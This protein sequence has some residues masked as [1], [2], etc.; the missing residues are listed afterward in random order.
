MLYA[1]YFALKC[2][3]ARECSCFN[4]FIPR[5]EHENIIQII[6][7][8]NRPQD[9]DETIQRRKELERDLRKCDGAFKEL[10]LDCDFLENRLRT[11]QARVDI[12]DQ[13]HQVFRNFTA[14][15][16]QNLRRISNLERENKDLRR[17]YEAVR[18]KRETRP[19]RDDQVANL[20]EINEDLQQKIVELKDDLL[21]E[22][23]RAKN[24]TALANA[25]AEI[26]RL[27]KLLVGLDERRKYELMREDEKCK[28]DK[29]CLEIEKTAIQDALAACEKRCKEISDGNGI[30][31]LRKQVAN[32]TADIK[33]LRQKYKK[34]L[35]ERILFEN[36]SQTWRHMYEARVVEVN[37]ENKR[38][39]MAEEEAAEYQRQAQTF[40]KHADQFAA[41]Y[42]SYKNRFDEIVTRI[43]HAGGRVVDANDIQLKA[44]EEEMK[45]LKTQ[46]TN[47]E[48]ARQM[49]VDDTALDLKRWIEAARVALLAVGCYKEQIDMAGL[50][51]PSFE[52]LIVH[53]MEEFRDS[54]QK[55]ENLSDAQEWIDAARKTIIEIGYK[56]EQINPAGLKPGDFE[57]AMRTK[58]RDLL[59]QVGSQFS[60]TLLQEV[61]NARQTQETAMQDVLRHL[62]ESLMEAEQNVTKIRAE[63]MILRAWK[64][65]NS[66]QCE[67]G[68]D[69]R[70]ESDP[71]ADHNNDC[72]D[73]DQYPSAESQLS[74]LDPEVIR[75]VYNDF[76][77]LARKF[78]R[79]ISDTAHTLDPG[80]VLPKWFSELVEPQDRSDA[81]I[82]DINNLTKL[83]ESLGSYVQDANWPGA[84]A[85]WQ[86]P[87]NSIRARV[88]Q[89]LR[90][91]AEELS[92]AASQAH[93]VAQKSSPA[94]EELV[95]VRS[96]RSRCYQQRP[97]DLREETAP[98]RERPRALYGPQWPLE[99]SPSVYPF[100]ERTLSPDPQLTG[101]APSP[102][103]A[104]I[105]GR[106][107]FALNSEN[108]EQNHP[109]P[110]PPNADTREENYRPN[111]YKGRD[112]KFAPRAQAEA[113]NTGSSSAPKGQGVNQPE[114]RSGLRKRDFEI[115][116]QGVAPNS[117]GNP[118][119]A[120]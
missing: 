25:R 19:L 34:E 84:R 27:E 90:E 116:G 22:K 3:H 43:N 89:G 17:R 110:K 29:S 88:G 10:K 119:N 38:R 65:A 115:R 16:K 76:A 26:A 81:T 12:C 100:M 42:L 60:N 46:L 9:P 41:S 48:I 92:R 8:D 18:N 107:G 96:W 23:F 49:A 70:V 20:P 61:Q 58:I 102:P 74:P 66:C 59:K 77:V 57:C 28:E 53:A 30:T 93:A 31:Q 33:A 112:G 40:H 47:C 54:L 80:F 50:T 71:C 105:R 106:R 117:P 103:V 1:R 21:Q 86:P 13:E 113:Q 68:C 111:Q 37:T 108:P 78:I 52:G 79:F 98:V 62:K 35:D 32:L 73:Q 45:F 15:T 6:R 24:D 83:V 97:S 87:S 94:K 56:E 118:Y 95:K 14:A 5:E 64:A 44:L 11:A 67:V 2:H 4:N 7:D 36:R 91:I 63:L 104:S 55:L 114:N 120:S 69:C 39:K 75:T 82:N 51:P 99:P 85:N 109:A 101:P 72:I